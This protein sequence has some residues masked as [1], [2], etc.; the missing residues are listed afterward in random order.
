VHVNGGNAFY[1]FSSGTLP[2]WFLWWSEGEL[3]YQIYYYQY[4]SPYGGILNK[5][6]MIAIAESMSDINDS[7]GNIFKPYEYVANYE[8]AL[9]FDIKEFPKTPAEWSFTNVSAYA[10]P[11]C[12]AIS[13]TAEKEIGRLYLQQ[14]NTDMDKYF[15]RYDIPQNAIEHVKI[16]NVNGQY[17][18]GNMEFEDQGKIV[19]NSNLPFRTLRW[20]EDGLWMQI[21]LSGDSIVSYDKDDLISYAESLK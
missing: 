17:I 5:E 16:G 10:Q 4:L 12:I 2:Y 15:E 7:R 1:A 11:D 18:I 8:Q 9:G 20:Q 21:V 19:W 14:C 6:K 3:N 13:Y